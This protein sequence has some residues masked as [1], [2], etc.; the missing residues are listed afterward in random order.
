MPELVAVSTR[1]H[2]APGRCAQAERTALPERP[3][4]DAWLADIIGGL[5]AGRSCES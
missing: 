5:A 4:F 2:P 3:G 1:P